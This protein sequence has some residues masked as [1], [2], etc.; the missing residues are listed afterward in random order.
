MEGLVS[1]KLKSQEGAIQRQSLKTQATLDSYA[2]Q[3]AAQTEVGATAFTTNLNKDAQEALT[4]LENNFK[5]ELQNMQYD[6][7][8]AESTRAQAASQ[9]QNTTDLLLRI[10]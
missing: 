3:A 5:I 1:G 8:R 6:A 2:K 9:I 10:F 4:T 7:T